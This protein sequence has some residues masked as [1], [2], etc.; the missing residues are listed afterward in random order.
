MNWLFPTES[1]GGLMV[2]E[3]VIP[4]GI[5]ILQVASSSMSW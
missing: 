3:L 1:P 5:N 2:P 4:H